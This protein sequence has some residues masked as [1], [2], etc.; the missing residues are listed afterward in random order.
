ME[1]MPVRHFE[2][3]EKILDEHDLERISIAWCNR[4]APSFVYNH[5]EMVT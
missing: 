1:A 2:Q 5:N 4:S 3:L